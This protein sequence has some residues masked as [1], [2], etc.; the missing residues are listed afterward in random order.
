MMPAI[1]KKTTILIMLAAFALTTSC[2]K[3][4][5]NIGK[6]APQDE[7]Q[8]CMKLSD[9]KRFEEAVECLEIFK[10]KFPQ[11]EY[12]TKAELAIGDNHFNRK[13]YLLAAQTY[14]T[15]IKMHPNSADSEYAY[16]RTGL[17]YLKESPKSIDRDQQYLEKAINFLRVAAEGF[18][19]GS[20]HEAAVTSL[21]DARS[22]VAK[23]EFY[24]GRFYYKTGQFVASIPR[25]ITV[26]NDYPD[27]VLAPEALYKLVNASGKL[28][29]VDDSKLYYSKLMTEYPNSEWTKK[30]E[31]KVKHY[32]EKYG[33]DPA[34][35]ML[36]P[37]ERN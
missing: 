26:A 19:K 31:S 6:G 24:I 20:Y 21:A 13:E 29:M 23:R 27:T 9:K 33:K 16:Y 11:G 36:T 8:K 10:S 18:T 1:M 15:F 2:A 5:I 37:K 22:R 28:R 14:E 34:Q 30:A 4:P 32:V 12:S 3:E 35:G 17:S 25:F 7:I